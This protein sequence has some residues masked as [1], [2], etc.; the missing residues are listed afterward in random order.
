MEINMDKL[1]Y[2]DKDMVKVLKGHL[3]GDD[4]HFVKMLCDGRLYSINKSVVISLRQEEGGD[5]DG[6]G[7]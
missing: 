3:T 4:E 5:G 6:L 2:T 7:H 1:V